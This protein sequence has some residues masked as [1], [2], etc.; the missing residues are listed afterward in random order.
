MSPQT[1]KLIAMA[2]SM[3]KE[4]KIFFYTVAIVCLLP[5]F[6]IIILTQAG[7]NIVS[8][9][10]ATVDTQT[11]QVDIHDPKT[12]DV[13]DSISQTAAWPVSGVVTLEFGERSP[14][15][16]FHTGIDIANGTVGDP[17]VA[18]MEGEVIYAGELSW[19]Y[20][21]HVKIDHGHHIVSIYAHL[22][23]IA[24]KEG[25]E[26]I[27]GTIIGTRGDTGWS[28]GPHTHFQINVFGI[29]VNPRVFLKGDP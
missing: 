15:Q 12:G 6:A 20:G 21:K 11:A 26:V 8:G 13:I 3:K 22:N 23:S 28:T 1:I 14:Y 18:F 24:V 10:L 7:L 25:D 29:P 5:V 16:F 2:F 19:G 9:A 27:P 4:M 17:V